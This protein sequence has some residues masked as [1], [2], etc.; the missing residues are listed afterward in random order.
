MG[1]RLCAASNDVLFRNIELFIDSL[2]ITHLSLTPS[3]AALVNPAHVPSVKMLVT[4]GEAVT[5]K[6]FRDWSGRGLFQGYGPSETTN[7]CSVHP[8]VSPSDHKN[9]IGK[10]LP[11]TSMFVSGSQTF[12]SLPKGALGEIWIGGDQVGRGY[13]ND[14]KLTAEKFVDHPEYGRL[15][16]SGDLGRM[17]PDGTMLFH[18]RQDDQVKLRGQ[19]IELGEIEHALLQEAAISDSVCLLVKDPEQTKGRLV[20]YWSTKQPLDVDLKSYVRSLS[21]RLQSQLP[22]YMV[23]DYLIEIDSFPLTSQGKTDRKS[24]SQ[25]FL[26]TEPTALR[27]YSTQEDSSCGTDL[28]EPDALRIAQAIAKVTGS[29]LSRIDHD[30]SFFALGLDSINCINLSRELYDLGFEQVDVS[31]ILRNASIAKL[32]H[33]LPAG[34]DQDIVLR[35]TDSGLRHVF[36][37]EWQE[38]VRTKYGERGFKVMK[39]LP[40]TPLQQ[41][42]LSHAEGDIDDLRQNQLSFSVLGDLQ[43]LEAAWSTCVAAHEILRTGFVLTESAQFPFA[44]VVLA[45]YACPWNIEN[46]FQQEKFDWEQIVL[47]PY[48]FTT[49]NHP[50][51]LLPRLVLKI[52]HALYDAQA[53]SLL[54][55]DVERAYMHNPVEGGPS[56]EPYLEY[57]VGLGEQDAKAFWGAYLADYRPKLVSRAFRERRSESKSEKLVASVSTGTS[58]QVLTESCRQNSITFL[59]LLQLTWARL[60]ATYFD[61]QDVCFG[62]VYSGRNL[63]L[64]DVDKII[65][66]CFNTLPVRTV[67]EKRDTNQQ[68]AKKLHDHNLAALRFQPLSLRLI[69]KNLGVSKL[70]DTLLLLQHNPV[71]LDSS[72]WNLEEDFGDMKFPLVLEVVPRRKSDRLD[73]I[74]H[75]DHDLLKPCGTDAILTGLDILLEHTVRYPDALATDCSMLERGTPFQS[76]HSTII[77]IPATPV[78]EPQ[79]NSAEDWSPLEH[80][81]RDALQNL[82]HGDTCELERDTTIFQLGLD[83]LSAIQIAADLKRKGYRVSSGDVLEAATVPKIAA[84]CEKHILNAREPSFSFNFDDFSK[85]HIAEACHRHSINSEVIEEIRP[86]TPFQCAILAEFVTSQGEYYLNSMRFELDG[87]IDTT[88]LRNTWETV[89]LRHD[90]LRTGFVEIDSMQS[91]FAMVLYFAKSSTLPWYEE[92]MSVNQH[93]EEYAHSLLRS[94]HEPPWRLTIINHGAHKALQFSI[95]HALFDAKTLELLHDEVI[96]AYRGNSLPKAVPVKPCLERILHNSSSE[97]TTEMPVSRNLDTMPCMKFPNLHPHNLE[98]LGFR[99]IEYESSSSLSQLRASCRTANATLSVAGQCAWG[100]LLSAYTGESVNVFGVVLSGRSVENGEEAVLFPCVNTLPITIEVDGISN[101]ELLARTAQHNARL[102]KNP[103][104]PMRTG[105]IFQRE[106]FDSLFV[107][108]NQVTTRQP[109]P[110]E[111]LAENARADY[112]VSIELLIDSRQKLRLRL[113]VRE[114]IVPLEQGKL[115][116]RQF[117]A[118]LLD[119]LHNL[120]GDASSFRPID[121]GLTSIVPAKEPLIETDVKHLHEFVENGSQ[122]F[123]T[124]TAFEFVVDLTS[125]KAVKTSRTYAQLNEEGNKVAH[126]LRQKGTVP[127]DLIGI[128]FD[129]CPEAS[130][131]I[132]GILKAGCAYVALD[133]EAPEARKRFILEDSGCRILCTTQDK[134]GS[135]ALLDDLQVLSID[136]VLEESNL[137]CHAVLLSREVAWDD[138]CYCLYTSG[139]TGTPKGCLVSHG[140]AVQFVLAF[141]RLFSGHWDADSRFLQF[142]SF[143]FDVSVM[144][145]FWSWSIGICVTSAPRDLLFE[146]LPAAIR[147]LEITHIDLT[148]SLARLLTP[149]DCPSLCRGAFITGGEQLRQDIIDA[150][151]DEGVVY[152]GYGPSEV[153][154]GCT[155]YPRIPKSTKPS[156]IGP[157]YDNVGA[158]V[159]D[160]RN[161][162]PVLKGGIG[163][164]CVSGPLVGKGYINRPELTAEKFEY[165]VHLRARVYHT[166]DLVRLLHDGSF[167]F[168]GRVDDQV[169]LRGQR[170]EVGEINHVVRRASQSIREVATM[171]LR[172]GEG[173]NQH[174]VTFITLSESRATIQ[175]TAVDF[176][177]VVSVLIHQIRKACKSALPAYMVPNYI[178]PVIAMP[179]SANNKINTKPLKQLFEATSFDELQQLSAAE[180]TS[181]Y[182]DSKA[183]KEVTRAI[184]R[185]IRLPENA[186]LGSSR[187][188]DLG[189]DSI[190]AISLSRL[191]R[192]SGFGTASPSMIMQN[193]VVADLLVALTDKSVPDDNESAKQ[194]AKQ[195]ITAFEETHRSAVREFLGIRAVDIERMAQC[196]A[197]QEGMIARTLNGS[198]G[199]YFSCFTFALVK[200]INVGRL[201]AAWIQ[202]ESQN[203]ILRTRFAPTGDGYAQVV[204]KDSFRTSNRFNVSDG[205]QRAR[206]EGCHKQD[207]VHWC[208]RVR[209][210]EKELWAVNIHRMP[211]HISMTLYMFHGL[212]DG[213]SLALVLEELA[214][215]YTGRT[216]LVTKPPYHDVLPLGPLLCP[217]GAQDFWI[218][219]LHVNH[220]LKL[221]MRYEVKESIVVSSKIAQPKALDEHKL[222]LEVTNMAIFQASWL[223]SLL[224][225]FGIMPTI[226][227]V[228]SGR[229]LDI[230]GIEN[231]VGPLFNTLPCSLE[232]GSLSTVVEVIKACHSFNVEAMPYQH[233]PLSKISK[234]LGQKSGEP[235][236]DSLFVFQ[237]EDGTLN[238]SRKLWTQTESISNPDY[239]IALEVEQ[240]VDQSLACTIVAQS[241]YLRREE[242]QELLNMFNATLMSVLRGSDQAL[243]FPDRNRP[244]N[245]DVPAEESYFKLFRGTGPITKGLDSG[246]SA[247]QWDAVSTVMRSEIAK[248]SALA[249]DD[250][251]PSTSI[252]Q[253][254]LDS[255]DAIKLST[256]LKSVGIAIS[257]SSILQ[258][259][260]IAKM[261]GRIAA[262]ANSSCCSPNPRLAEVKK[263]LHRILRS[264]AISLED[265][266]NVLPATPLQESM[267]ANYEQYYS[268]DLV[269][270]SPETNVEKLKSA[271]RLVVSAHDILR[272][273]FVEIEDPRSAVTYAQLVARAV[274][275]DCRSTTLDSEDE[276]QILLSNNASVASRRASNQSPLHLTFISI[277][278]ATFLIV[279]L[280]HA[281]YDGWSIN[282]LHE[283]VV[284]CYHELECVRPSYEPFL[285]HVLTASSEKSSSFWKHLLRGL[286]PRLHRRGRDEQQPFS[287]TN[288]HELSSKVPIIQVDAFCRAEGVTL[289][290][291]AITCLAFVLA[292]SL[293]IRDVCFGVVLAGRD[294]ENADRM[295]FPTMNTTA[296]RIMLQGNKLE[297]VQKVHKLAIAISEHQHFPLRTAKSFVKGLTGQLFDTLF[298]YQKRPS[299]TRQ[300]GTLYQSLGGLS[301]PEYPINIEME[302]LHNDI[303][304]R[305]ASQNDI[306]DVQDTQ[307]LLRHIDDVLRAIIVD[308]SKPAFLLSTDGISICDLP[309]FTDWTDGGPANDNDNDTTISKE[310][311]VDKFGLSSNKEIISQVLADI[312]KVERDKVTSSTNLFQLGLDSISAIKVSSALKMRSISLPVSKMLKALTVQRMAEGAKSLRAP[313]D[314]TPAHQAGNNIKL[315]DQEPI[316]RDLKRAGIQEGQVEYILPC[317]SGQK[318]FLGMW[319]ASGGSLFYPEFHYRLQSPTMSRQAINTA[320]QRLV[321]GVPMLRTIF[322]S[323]SARDAP[324][325]QIVLKDAFMPLLWTADM[326]RDIDDKKS[327]QPPVMLLATETPTAVMLQLRIHHALYDGVSLPRMIDAFQSL[328]N[329]S[330]LSSD[331]GIYLQDYLEYLQ[332]HAPS[333]QQ[334]SFWTSY[335]KGAPPFQS[336]NTTSFEAGRIEMFQPNLIDNLS[337]L[338]NK[339]KAH[340]VSFQ[341]LFFAAYARVHYKLLS[342]SANTSQGVSEVVVGIY[343]ANRSHDHGDLS[344]MLAP[345]VNVVPL[346]L[347]VREGSSLFDSATTIQDDLG[348]ISCIEHST[349]SLSDIHEWT[350]VKI[351]TFLNF[352]KFADVEDRFILKA[353]DTRLEEVERKDYLKDHADEPELP[354]PFANRSPVRQDDIYLVRSP[355]ASQ[356]GALLTTLQPSIDIEASIRNGVLDVGVFASADLLDRHRMEDLLKELRAL[357]LDCE[358]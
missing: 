272:T 81:I 261:V 87:D 343:L 246:K 325:L 147:S 198:D 236:F 257:V 292:H 319:Q 150:W 138:I 300:S 189:M 315:L 253:L 280:P 205:H 97:K 186:I 120:D 192:R 262:P 129:K 206:D 60:L 29:P 187:L 232:V 41:A 196:T 337:L 73:L 219:R 157:A 110:W 286:R 250:V 245:P 50:K 345:T 347:P 171:V 141:Q 98:G 184:S 94:L 43:Q 334:R 322:L 179:L 1:M 34:S 114:Q 291:L 117:D 275:L 92:D 311:N 51:M 185:V 281:V 289:Q 312:A 197:L 47:P 183:I 249:V 338:E 273:S 128:C 323:N 75:A 26:S 258:A 125:G 65:G 214:C 58:L 357:L 240:W 201:Q 237:K 341:A 17:L 134:A 135:L 36:S 307:A 285:E 288:R 348:K 353:K 91:P 161:K 3:V 123:P 53:I 59:A 96:A 290:S 56:L 7:I 45:D 331:L 229:I 342:R 11:N 144:E 127:G 218:K 295:M 317:T 8:N 349:V 88:H 57:M 86:C 172:H 72:I 166:G 259:G 260:S 207:F 116:A 208:Q 152:N 287:A 283:D 333:G 162:Q 30:T 294:V 248:L 102:L 202:V 48:S 67:F 27:K 264:Q 145:Q 318:F 95:L 271:W 42:M 175:D 99:T 68:A 231:A 10:P 329:E 256:R 2:K 210:L 113:T 160:T 5:S 356:V 314:H 355:S 70:F 308:P 178:I 84:F 158:Y 39:I 224:K 276:L 69:Q 15:Y 153:T 254:G 35:G 106:R 173:P 80:F 90:I 109:P 77:S 177:P 199:T 277:G 293:K 230:D 238:E 143:H 85:K 78:Q 328:C 351:N 302:P 220:L 235:L 100:R 140:N 266:E 330:E 213:I 265:F 216:R 344:E 23:P 32:L 33:S 111:V 19:R 124:R 320:W 212:Y 268:Q 305:A 18:G 301:D 131:A 37:L 139:T 112:T 251:A 226:G 63:P 243:E 133:P 350:G 163:E 130:F 136:K 267:L 239:P 151:G 74:L 167:C 40:C 142:A 122:Q 66:P 118:L 269:R 4:A 306:L 339:L 159:L 168:I 170:L 61:E 203:E 28:L 165:L 336:F 332:K 115:L 352:L 227:V 31:L 193:P 44:Q 25:L 228:V 247:F 358:H 354:C 270:I 255:I 20:A 282:L 83:S 221:P 346:R 321:Q 299:N 121:H 284:K 155:M 12:C 304:W 149:E 326:V 241:Q 209:G 252:F 335:L 310:I 215:N 190:T 52:H 126:F 6:V 105:S 103:Y 82:S 313:S 222:K 38:S 108:Q 14:A 79:Q 327:A 298:I 89:F 164:L 104:A 204:L 9:N 297:M 274:N 24:L 93:P 233:T 279:G 278:S 194:A 46:R 211:D 101:G 55:Q 148:P 49:V 22:T 303:V 62:N 119:T 174:L 156:N 13:L 169:K 137:P 154:I 71:D 146:D 223:I 296:F 263:D 191:L 340:A 200:S 316:R 132:I 107:F 176:S 181:R 21:E 180:A 188:F 217:S 64:R 54:L 195:R 182:L 225:K 234:W 324:M 309:A 242:V 76:L 16:Q 244:A